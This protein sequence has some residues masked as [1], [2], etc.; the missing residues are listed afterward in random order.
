[1]VTAPAAIACRPRVS[2]VLPTHNRVALLERAVE[3]VLG[4]TTADIELIIVDDVSQDG[5]GAYLATLGK[6]DSRVRAVRTA[7]AKGGAGA[8]N[9]GLRFCRGEWTAFL[10][11]DDQWLPTKL[12]RQLELLSAN[13]SAVACSCGYVRCLPSGASKD[14]Q[15]VAEA[16]LQ[17]LLEGSVLGS[18]SLC[19]CST[20][21]LMEIGGFDPT[22]RSAQDM[23]LWIRLRQRGEIV[24]CREFL[25]LYQVHTG[26]RISTDMNSQY[27]GSR[28]FYFKHRH[29]MDEPL[30]R[31][32]V[33]YTCFIMSRQHD[34][35]IRRRCHYLAVALIN[36]A[37]RVSLKYAMSSVPRLVRDFIL[38]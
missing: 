10:D 28:R 26:P 17:Q 31:H 1:V 24:A 3:S 19:M 14:V 9:E 18:A 21:V 2:V 32:R 15:V 29:L 7:A 12:Q 4:Q 30:R 6:R 27:A 23:D 38:K 37:P 22:L 33:A 5:T 11:D 16:T 20:R 13:P 25:V 35:G 36:A 34:R 8:R